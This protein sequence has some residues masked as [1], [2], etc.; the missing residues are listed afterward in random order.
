MKRPLQN[1][2]GQMIVEYILLSALA[3]TVTVIVSS[4][5]KQNEFFG[6]VV[7]S[8]WKKLSGMIQ[9]GQWGDP[10]STMSNHPNNHSLSTS[11][12][13]EDVQ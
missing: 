10:Q 13:G 3:I 4:Y 12:R 8:P 1:E 7:A 11:V 2:S 6:Q 5:M 9:N